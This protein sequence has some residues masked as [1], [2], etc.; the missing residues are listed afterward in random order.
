M[1][2]VAVNDR[3][4]GLLFAADS[5]RPAASDAVVSLT[6]RGLSVRIASG[7]RREAVWAAAAA[8]GVPQEAAS[9][10]ATPGES[11]KETGCI[12]DVDGRVKVAFE[13]TTRQG[14]RRFVA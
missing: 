7:D 1:V 14:R 6:E 10:G 3:P 13:R 11:R 12:A 8:A 2:V 5:V 9:W 4:V